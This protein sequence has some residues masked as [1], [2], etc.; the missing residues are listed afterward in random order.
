M[1]I[2][3]SKRE[4]EKLSQIKKEAWKSLSIG[5]ARST[6]HIDDALQKS[7]HVPL[8][9]FDI[10]DT[11]EFAESNQM[12]MSELASIK[13]FSRSGLTRIVDRLEKQGFVKREPCSA[14]GR[15]YYAVLT[16]K[17]REARKNALP[18][19]ERELSTIFGSAVTEKQAHDLVSLVDR[20]ILSSDKET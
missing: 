17:G 9:I 6:K 16:E 14:D 18:I 15:G 4:V 12:R 19:Y 11:L 5:Y 8:D 2:Q 7:G 13:A 3:G 20:I 1:L 10:L